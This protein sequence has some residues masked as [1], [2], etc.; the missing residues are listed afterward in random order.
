VCA[1][2][3]VASE[4]L[5]LFESADQAK[6]ERALAIHSPARLTRRPPVPART[7]DKRGRSRSRL[8]SRRFNRTR[9]SRCGCPTS[10][11]CPSPPDPRQ[12]RHADRRSAP[13]CTER[14]LES[15]LG[16]QLFKSVEVV[17]GRSGVLT[18]ASRETRTADDCCGEL[19]ARPY[20]A[21]WRV[22]SPPR[23]RGQPTG[24]GPSRSVLPPTRIRSP[25]ASR[26]PPAV[27]IAALALGH[28]PR[29]K[30]ARCK[31]R[32]SRPP[33]AGRHCV[34]PAA[35]EPWVGKR[36]RSPAK[37]AFL[38][39]PPPAAN[40]VSVCDGEGYSIEAHERRILSE[41]AEARPLGSLETQVFA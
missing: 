21:K 11:Y 7:C 26:R 16:R 25:L 39:H 2:R 28:G 9:Q 3:A 24:V 32:A 12:T 22:P 17:V 6:V 29:P 20:P 8:P 33:T 14:S 36:L 34:V 19:R 38:G 37:P 40:A 41:V 23:G 10:G 30:T 35:S 27:S 15:G 5:S 1:E 13:R 18:P 4:P 31:H